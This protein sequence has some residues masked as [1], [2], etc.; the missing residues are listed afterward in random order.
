[1]SL[2]LFAVDLIGNKLSR[3]VETSLGVGI[4]IVMI[5]FF[6][7][8]HLI[9]KLPLKDQLLEF[10]HLNKPTELDVVG[11]NGQ[12]AFGIKVIAVAMVIVGFGIAL[13]GLLASRNMPSIVVGLSI[14]LIAF[15]TWIASKKV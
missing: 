4:P 11:D 2:K 3:I 8:F 14:I 13:L 5:C 9:K 7:V 10:A 15:P 1:L 6:E 12:N